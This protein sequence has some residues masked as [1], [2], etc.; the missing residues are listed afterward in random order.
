MLGE[1]GSRGKPSAAFGVD[2]FVIFIPRAVGISAGGRQNEKNEKKT[3][4][5]KYKRK[6]D[7]KKRRGTPQLW[8]LL[9]EPQF[10]SDRATP[11]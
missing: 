6:I 1:K 11:E 10:L 7:G 4:K 2:G 9:Y 5:T 8:G 3:K